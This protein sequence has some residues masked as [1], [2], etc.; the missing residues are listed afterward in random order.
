MVLRPPAG[1]AVADDDYR[2]LAGLDCRALYIAHQL[3]VGTVDSLDI[4]ELGQNRNR[5]CKIN[6]RSQGEA[7]SD[8]SNNG[9]KGDSREHA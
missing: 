6:T 3:A 5:P 9:L 1:K 2:D 8:S 4:I 7:Y